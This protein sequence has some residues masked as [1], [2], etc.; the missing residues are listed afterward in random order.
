ML[1]N[2]MVNLVYMGYTDTE[3]N[4]RRGMDRAH[5]I[6]PFRSV[7]IRDITDICFARS[8]ACSLHMRKRGG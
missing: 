6:G 7:R 1:T 5:D 8:S 4:G 3:D 2:L